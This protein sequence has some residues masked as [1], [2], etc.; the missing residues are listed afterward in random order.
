MLKFRFTCT[1]IQKWVKW[2]AKRKHWFLL[3]NNLIIMKQEYSSLVENKR[4]K[5]IKIVFDSL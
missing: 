5:N 1:V 4:M 2:T 3:L